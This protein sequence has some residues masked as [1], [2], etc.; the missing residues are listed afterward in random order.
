MSTTKGGLNIVTDNLVL[1]LDASNNKSYVSGSTKWNDLSR[2]NTNGTLINGSTYNS[3]N[4]GN[5]TFDGVDDYAN[6]GTSINFS[7][8]TSGFTIGFW[9]KMLNTTNLN[10][11][12]FSKITDVGND[13]Q[14]SVAYGYVSQTLELYSGACTQN[15]RTNSQILINDNNWHFVYYTLGITTTGYL[16]GVVKFTNTYGTTPVFLSS[17]NTNFIASFNGSQNFGNIAVSSMVL[18]NRILTQTEILQNYNT[19]RT[20]FGL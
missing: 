17:T 20:K 11:Y 4:G 10:R 7:T 14:F 2:S 15:I 16:D 3:S 19:T 1:Y 18:Y 13:N 6:L 8:Y 5:I 9:V 12:V